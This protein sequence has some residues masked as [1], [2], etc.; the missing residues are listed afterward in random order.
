M[1]LFSTFCSVKQGQTFQ[2]IYPHAIEIIQDKYNEKTDGF[3][4]EKS[5]EDLQQLTDQF[6]SKNFQEYTL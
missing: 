2:N 5:K 4:M 1:A 3:D 6:L